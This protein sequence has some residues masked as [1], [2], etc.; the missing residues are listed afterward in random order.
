MSC[1]SHWNLAHV[2]I[3]STSSNRELNARRR[4]ASQCKRD[5]APFLSRT[6][7]TVTPPCPL[8]KH[9]GVRQGNAPG[10]RSD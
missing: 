5:L 4:I 8:R 6:L 1:T 7:R 2:A 10:L 9:P 3:V